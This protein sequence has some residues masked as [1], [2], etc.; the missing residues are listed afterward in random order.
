VDATKTD[1]INHPLTIDGFGVGDTLDITDLPTTG[2]TQSFNSTTDQLTLTNG[3]TVI[4][5][6]FNSS[7]AGDHFVLTPTA[8]GKGTDVTLAT[9]PGA[10]LAS[11]AH[12]V[13]NFVSGNSL[14]MNE[15]FLLGGHGPGSSLTLADPSALDPGIYGSASHASLGH[16]LVHDVSAVFKA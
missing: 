11:L 10:T 16:S 8:N 4:T 3:T 14:L 1:L 9:G 6:G 5:L 13:R 2:T 15:K 12:D 7:V